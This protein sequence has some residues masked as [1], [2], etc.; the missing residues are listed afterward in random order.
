M[1]AR[2][3]TSECAGA[4]V[5]GVAV[6]IAVNCACVAFTYPGR[7]LRRR[8]D[9][10]TVR[11]GQHDLDNRWVVDYNPYLSTKYDCHI[12]V[13]IVANVE[14][15]KYIYKYVYKGHDCTE[16]AL[17][18]DAEEE[19]EGAPPSEGGPG[20]PRAPS[21]ARLRHRRNASRGRPPTRAAPAR[22]RASAPPAGAAGPAGPAGPTGSASAAGA[23]P[24]GR[25]LRREIDEIQAFQDAR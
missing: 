20:H 6:V 1:P 25:A 24:N 9:G 17:T 2:M 15:V 8:E 10:R 4:C 3:V 5:P 21:A 23:P 22:R 14:A 19:R 16:F 7:R 11:K 13:E 18:E 12:N